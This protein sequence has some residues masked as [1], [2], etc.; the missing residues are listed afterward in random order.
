MNGISLFSGAGIGE[1]YLDD[2][3]INIVVA[4]EIVPRRAELYLSLI[5]I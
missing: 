1:T 2:I 3:G 5:H 4:N